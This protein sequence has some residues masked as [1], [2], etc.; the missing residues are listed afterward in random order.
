MANTGER[1]MPVL[2]PDKNSAS[3]YSIKHLSIEVDAELAKVLDAAAL[4][5]TN[6][7]AQQPPMGDDNLIDRLTYHSGWNSRDVPG[8]ELGPTANLIWDAIDEI[9]RLRAASLP[10]SDAV[11]RERGGIYIAS[12]TKHAH[13]WLSMRDQGEPIISTWIDDARI[14]KI[15][16]FDDF[17]RRTIREISSCKVFIIYRRPD[18]ILMDALVEFGIAVASETPIFAVGFEGQFSI[19]GFCQVTHFPTIDSAFEA[20]TRSRP[21][22]EPVGPAQVQGESQSSAAGYMTPEQIANAKSVIRSDPSETNPQLVA[23]RWKDR[24]AEEW[25]LSDVRPVNGLRTLIIEP[26]YASPPPRQALSR[27]DMDDLYRSEIE[28]IIDSW[29]A[30]ASARKFATSWHYGELWS[31]IRDAILSAQ[32]QGG[33]S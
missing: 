13:R 22:P 20:T 25:N 14:G 8:V 19:A 5:G 4:P 29:T 15:T 27:E 11:A 3:G 21:T 33:A 12:K 18:E 28:R 23:W 6:A 1:T 24:N 26:L 7:P 30:A 31:A 2:V 10:G 9:R 32:S 17:W 16:D